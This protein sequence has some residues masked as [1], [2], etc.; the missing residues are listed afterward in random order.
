MWSSPRNLS[1]AMM[2][3]WRQRSDTT[4]FD[5]PLYAHYLRVTGREHPGRDE[6]LASQDNDGA[7]VVRDVMLRDYGTP[8]VF[9]KQMAK[10]LVDLDRSFLPG[11][12]NIV[13]TRDPHDML[14]SFQVNMPD[15]T[16]DDTGFI[17]LNEILDT[18]LAAGAEPIVIETKTLLADPRRVLGETC[19]RLGIDFDQAM[20]SWPAGPKPEDGVWAKHWYHGVHRSTGWQPHVG[21]EADL[22]PELVPVLEQ[23][24][25]LY[26]RLLA[27]ATT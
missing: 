9:F 7:G 26:E 1:T 4:V 5:E 11:F 17:E 21:K 22:L 20:L 6:I 27:Y 14:T 25:P 19:R 8:V 16:I 13:L 12:A 3:A 23:S 2:Y 24:R 15:T 18:L 10:H